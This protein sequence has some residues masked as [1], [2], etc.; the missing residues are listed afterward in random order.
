MSSAQSRNPRSADP[1]YDLT[2]SV[3]DFQ[4]DPHRDTAFLNARL[5][6][7]MLLD[8]TVPGGRTL[9]VACGVG[10]LAVE[11]TKAG[12]QGWGLEPSAEMTGVGR[13]LFPADLSVLVRGVGEQLPFR[14]ASFDRLVCQGALDHFVSPDVFMREAARVIRPHGRIVI[15]IAN[16][17]S[18]SCRLGRLAEHFAVAS[19]GQP[20]AA[21]R[22]YWQPPPDHFHKG[23]LSFV[24][25]LG[26]ELLELERC[27]GIS[28][29]W[30]LRHRRIFHWG[31]GL[32]L[33]PERLARM[34][35]VPLDRLAQAAP[36]HADMI[37]SVW[38]H[39]Q[40]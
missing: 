20:K 28:L 26:G 29:L 35:L 34:I 2:Y 30:L 39:R 36:A 1:K 4:A 25:R 22:P 9:D 11:I 18:I 27:Y 38:R 40:R 33:L 14:D 21:D 8:S 31:K 6:E 19:L 17:E 23:Q 3:N 15:A 10:R 7:A 5:E 24:R 32:D 13:W 16:Y 37:V 12:G